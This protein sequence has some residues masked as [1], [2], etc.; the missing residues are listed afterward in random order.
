MCRA[1]TRGWR[2]WLFTSAPAGAIVMNPKVIK[3]PTPAEI[4]SAGLSHYADNNHRHLVAPVT[5]DDAR[6]ALK[7]ILP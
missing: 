2:P 3:K 5:H 4:G 1:S 6:E 7:Q